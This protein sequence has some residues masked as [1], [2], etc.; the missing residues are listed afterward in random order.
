[1]II[2]G[3]GDH[4][5][6]MTKFKIQYT[7]NGNEWI[8]YEDGKVFEGTPRR[9]GKKRYNLNPFYAITVR[10]VAIAW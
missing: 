3:R 9:N 4:D 2:Q 7:L 6:M 1:M 8:D 5:F 10:I